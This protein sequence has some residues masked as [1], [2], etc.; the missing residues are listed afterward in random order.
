MTSVEQRLR[1]ALQARADSTPLSENRPLP[2]MQLGDHGR[3]ARRALAMIC[4]LVAVLCVGG[5]VALDRLRPSSDRQSTAPTEPTPDPTAVAS[6]PPLTTIEQP[7]TSLAAS[8]TLSPI[9]P[10]A[11]DMMDRWPEALPDTYPDLSRVP[12]LLPTID[13]LSASGATRVEQADNVTLAPRYI[14][15]W[16]GPDAQAILTITTYPGQASTIPESSREP[17]GQISG[18]DDSF[19]G[20]STPDVVA[21]S[22][23]DPSGMVEMWSNS[24]PREQVLELASS[25]ERRALGT[26]GWDVSTSDA[27]LIS[28]YEGWSIGSAYRV[29]NWNSDGPVGEMSIVSGAPDLFTSSWVSSAED[30][31]LTEVGT[32]SAL[33]GEQSGLAAVVWSPQPNI[34]VRLG[35]HG[36]LEQALAIARS[37]ELADTAAWGSASEPGPPASDCMFC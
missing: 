8:T 26:A 6:L 27:G 16:F 10:S 2:M 30:R 4:V 32:A 33:A 31:V 18:W 21:L 13:V 29:V 20:A 23:V 19:L 34:V 17:V 11:I 22:L 24:L 9:T 28:V 37:V 5:L 35:I 7:S 12:T 1:S 15:T 3:P 36:N 25:L 14:Q